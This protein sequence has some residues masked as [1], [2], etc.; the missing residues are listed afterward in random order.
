MKIN[1][2]NKTFNSLS[3]I[4]KDYDYDEY[5]LKIYRK[6]HNLTTYQILQRID[7]G[8]ID[9]KLFQSKG[10]TKRIIKEKER[11]SY[12]NLLVG[13]NFSVLNITYENILEFSKLNKISV[14]TI[15]KK[16]SKSDET[17]I[18]FLE[19]LIN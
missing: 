1:F 5:S 7:T 2:K 6:Q 14:N 13:N 16:I 3:A 19:S 15:Y 11:L 17:P 8:N 12:L 4:I 9:E 10:N 18:N